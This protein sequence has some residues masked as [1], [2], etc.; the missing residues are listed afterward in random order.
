MSLKTLLLALEEIYKKK[1]MLQV[2]F[3]VTMEIDGENGVI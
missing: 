2:F 1:A 3:S